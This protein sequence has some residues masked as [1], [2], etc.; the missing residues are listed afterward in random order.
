MDFSMVVQGSE[1]F[2]FSENQLK[3]VMISGSYYTL[4]KKMFLVAFVLLHNGLT[5]CHSTVSVL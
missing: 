2:F 3:L 1:L 4:S 5:R